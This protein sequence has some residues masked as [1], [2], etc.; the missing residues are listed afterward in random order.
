[1]KSDAKNRNDRSQKKEQ[2]PVLTK[3]INEL[4]EAQETKQSH[5]TA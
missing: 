5:T 2:F 4:A 1:M 3:Y